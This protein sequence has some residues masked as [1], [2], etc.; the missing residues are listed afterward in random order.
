MGIWE[1]LFLLLLVLALGFTAFA[2]YRWWKFKKMLSYTKAMVGKKLEDL[3]ILPQLKGVTVGLNIPKK[4]EVVIYFYGPNCKFC[5]KQ[6]E[7]LKK[8][9]QN[10]KLFKFDVRTKRGKIMGAVFRVSVLPSVIVLRDRVIKAYFTAFATAD[11]IVK[12]I[13]ED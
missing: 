13:K 11:R 6:E 5:P 9:P 8:L 1:I 4:G 3:I 7:E 2:V 10:L 12:A